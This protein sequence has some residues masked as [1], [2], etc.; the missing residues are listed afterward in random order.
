[1]FSRWV[2]LI[3]VMS[4]VA[5]VGYSGSLIKDAIKESIVNNLARAALL[6][7]F[8]DG[9]TTVDVTATRKAVNDSAA[10]D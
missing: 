1:M 8:T 6:A 5:L 2:S 9:K 7:T 3:I 4:G 10:P